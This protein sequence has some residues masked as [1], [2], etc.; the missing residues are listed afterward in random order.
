MFLVGYYGRL[1][2]RSTKLNELFL[3]LL[4]CS[5][6]LCRGL[7]NSRVRVDCEA[8]IHT[9]YIYTR[10]RMRTNHVATALLKANSQH[11]RLPISREGKPFSTQMG[12]KMKKRKGKIK[13]I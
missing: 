2:L 9:K 6:L 5:K 3:A 7:P 10:R 12:K 8:V 11:S 4:C 1:G 13:R